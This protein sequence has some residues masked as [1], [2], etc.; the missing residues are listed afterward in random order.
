MGRERE[1]D[2]GGDR[3]RERERE[4]ERDGYKD[5]RERQCKREMLTCIHAYFSHPSSSFLCLN[6]PLCPPPPLPHPQVASV[7]GWSSMACTWPLSARTSPPTRSGPRKPDPEFLL[8]SYLILLTIRIYLWFREYKY[9]SS[10]SSSSSSF[11]LYY[12]Y[13]S[14]I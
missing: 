3:E 13:Y 6:Q 4:R 7:C 14:R 5:T 11:Y 10:S 12:Y 9:D 2:K 8:I 1:G